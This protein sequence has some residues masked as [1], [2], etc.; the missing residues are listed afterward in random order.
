VVSAVAEFHGA[1]LAVYFLTEME[2]LQQQETSSTTQ[3]PL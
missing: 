1:T 3:L 2:G